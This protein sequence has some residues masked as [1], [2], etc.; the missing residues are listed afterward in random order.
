MANEVGAGLACELI[1]KLEGEATRLGLEEVPE[2]GVIEQ[3]F[4]FD[5]LSL[6]GTRMRP[7]RWRGLMAP[8]AQ[9]SNTLDLAV[10]P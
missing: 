1:E 5:C 10:D 8:P 7:I 3:V 4:R 2:S 9:V 6:P